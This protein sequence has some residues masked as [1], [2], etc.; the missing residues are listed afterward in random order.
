MKSAELNL[1]VHFDALI[2]ARGVSQAA[3]AM[4]ISQPAMSAALSRLRYLF[5]DPL[6]Q[7]DGNRWTPTARALQLH[8]SFQPLLQAWHRSTSPE[9]AFVPAS[10]ERVFNIF[11][12]D[13][14][15][16]VLL[17]RLAHTLKAEAPG[18]GLRCLPPKLAGAAEM[19]SGSYVELYLGHLPEPPDYLRSRF[20]F[21]EPA[22]CLLRKG[23][24]A[25]QRGWDL[26]AYLQHEHIDS[27]GY[28]GYFSAQ[29]DAALR[30]LGGSRKVALLLSSYLATPFVVAQ[31]DL[32]ATL[33]GGVA[34]Q[35]AATT[36]TVLVPA[37]LVL[38]PLSISLYWHE[39]YQSDAGHAW[40]RNR[41]CDSVS[42]R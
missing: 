31:T 10:A 3:K 22:T 33:P 7:R 37:P 42:K 28:V 35:L 27:V 5:G 34:R 20:L 36:D 12:S 11:V 32:I 6:L 38:P 41:I 16:L 40:L 14:L 9:A 4:G 29:V 1:L 13:Y 21:E 19:L 18:I 39:R 15:Q 24:P 26:E 8:Q 25:L 17:P 2:S 23:H 30:A